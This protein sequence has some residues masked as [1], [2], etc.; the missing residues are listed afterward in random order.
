MKKEKIEVFS[1]SMY[2]VVCMSYA[3]G[4]M[5]GWNHAWYLPISLIFYAYPF[6]LYNKRK[7]IELKA[8]N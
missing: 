8:L 7:Q 4:F 5:G 2:L 3:F 1:W 6:Y